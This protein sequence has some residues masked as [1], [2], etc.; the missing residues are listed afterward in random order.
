MNVAVEIS[1]E[2]APKQQRSHGIDQGHSKRS[3]VKG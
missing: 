1:P 3:D 2:N